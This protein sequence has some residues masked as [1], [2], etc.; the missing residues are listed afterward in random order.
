MAEDSGSVEQILRVN[1][2]GERGAICIYRSQVA[3]SRLFYP[4]CVAAL[5]EMLSHEERHYQTFDAILKTRGIRP[6]HALALWAVGGWI[7]GAMT[8]LLGEHAIWACTAAIEQTVNN[9][10]VSQITFLQSNDAEVLSAVESIRRDEQAHEDHAN[11]S[12]GQGG[13][14]LVILRWFIAS[15]TS[16]AIWLSTKL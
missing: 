8:A 7:L 1:H 13:G 6:C 15:A 16:F 12:G 11:R 9:H 14:T 4:V 10:L 2:A 3:V 5:T